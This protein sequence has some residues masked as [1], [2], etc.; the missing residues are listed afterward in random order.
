MTDLVCLSYSKYNNLAYEINNKIFILLLCNII[1]LV[2]NG[3]TK[4]IRLQML[5][6]AK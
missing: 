5:Y 6:L 1:F 3:I 2:I 4:D